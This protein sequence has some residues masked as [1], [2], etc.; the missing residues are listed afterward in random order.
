MRYRASG[1]GLGASRASVTSHGSQ[2]QRSF[3]LL[4]LTQD[5]G[6]KVPQSLQNH[7]NREL[8]ASK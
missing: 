5:P 7:F 2:Q 6:K 4:A 1:L 3:N 8:D